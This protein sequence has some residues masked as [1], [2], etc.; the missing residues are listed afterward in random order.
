MLTALSG[1]AS[2]VSHKYKLFVH[3]PPK[4]ASTSILTALVRLGNP[5]AEITNDASRENLSS[6]DIHPYVRDHCRPTEQ[7]LRDIFA[8][9]DFCKIL[10]LRDPLS[11]FLSAIASKY[12]IGSGPMLRNSPW[13]QLSSTSLRRIIRI[14][15]INY[16]IMCCYNFN[17]PCKLFSFFKKII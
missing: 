7:C 15:K 4:C 9:S 13:D 3:A 16:T 6:L 10:V 8:S 11:R 2:F 1:P 14:F 12:L 17:C 5:N